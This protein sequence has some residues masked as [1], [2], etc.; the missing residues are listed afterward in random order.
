MARTTEFE[1]NVA[2]ERAVDVFWDKGY[3]DTSMDDLIKSMGV[4]RYGVYNTW[5]NK[6]ELFLAALKKY[7]DQRIG[8][9]K[10]V[11]RKSDASIPEIKG[12][13]KMLLKQP[14]DKHSGCF[15]CNAAI[16]LAPHDQDV[17][18]LIRDMFAQ[19]AGEFRTALGNAVDKGELKTEFK[20]DDLAD[21]L[22]NIIRSTMVMT[23]SGYSRKKIT[24]YMNIALNV[25]N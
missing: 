11:L 4:A 21:Y 2:L 8:L 12:F 13:F 24:N 1:P 17:A 20:L 18:D 5:G 14:M 9:M 10:G 19:L 22:A 6:R 25:L 7:I 15:A 3:F 23:R 16:E